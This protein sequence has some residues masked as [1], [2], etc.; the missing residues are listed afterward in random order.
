MLFPQGLSLRSKGTF[1]VTISLGIHCAWTRSR[2]SWLLGQGC[3]G[4]H[5][6]WQAGSWHNL[7]CGCAR[8][9]CWLHLLLYTCDQVNRQKRKCPYTQALLSPQERFVWPPAEF[10]HL[11]HTSAL[12]DSSTEDSVQKGGIPGSQLVL[13]GMRLNYGSCQNLGYLLNNHMR[14]VFRPLHCIFRGKI[15]EAA[16]EMGAEL[17]RRTYYSHIIY[18]YIYSFSSFSPHPGNFELP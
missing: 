17:W 6:F 18:I 10:C 11:S 8:V 12:Q 3:L 7:K 16:A 4:S 15:L 9:Q 5:H 13:G 1:S 14:T 2:I